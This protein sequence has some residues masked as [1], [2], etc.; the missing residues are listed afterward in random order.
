MDDYNYKFV[1][2]NGGVYC[3]LS[4]MS[5][6]D[7]STINP[8]AEPLYNISLDKSI[9]FDVSN[10]DISEMFIAPSIKDF[11]MDFVYYTEKAVPTRRNKKRRIQKK[12][13]KRYGYKIIR[14]KHTM[15][16]MTIEQIR[17]SDFIVSQIIKKDV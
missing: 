13:I 15:R 6:L 7:L 17:D 3:E 8:N 9:E 10:A 11:S 5:V 2:I 4:P 16:D 14:E 12:W 1:T